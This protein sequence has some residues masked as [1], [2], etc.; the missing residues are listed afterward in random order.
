M[1][2]VTVR[3]DLLLTLVSCELPLTVPAVLEYSSGDPYAVRMVFYPGA[4]EVRWVFSR[5]ILDEGLIREAGDGDVQ[6]VPVVNETG[7]QLVLIRLAA[8]GGIA[9]LE[10]C[11]DAVAEFVTRIFAVVPSGAEN[12]HLAVDEAIAVLLA[13]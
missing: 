10:A 2:T 11:P 4:D 3:R 8:P 13:A 1:E 7:E 12:D 5:D 9:V 6:V